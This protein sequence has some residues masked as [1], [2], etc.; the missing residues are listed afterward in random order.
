MPT[1][2]KAALQVSAPLKAG[3]PPAFVHSFVLEPQG[4]M[5]GLQ[6]ILVAST[7]FHAFVDS[8][9]SLAASLSRLASSNSGEGDVGVF[10]SGYLVDCGAGVG[11]PTP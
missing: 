9:R 10:V 7:P 8:S 11:C 6:D 3:G 2:Q 5:G 1:G 4:T